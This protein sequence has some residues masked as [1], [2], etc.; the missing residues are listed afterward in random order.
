[1]TSAPTT[2]VDET[3]PQPTSRPVVPQLHV[4]EDRIVGGVAGFIARSFGVDAA[5]VRIGFVLLTLASG[6]GAVLY[7]GLWLVLSADR[8]TRWHW[9]RLVG[10][11]IVVVGIPLIAIA[12]AG[13]PLVDGPAA[14]VLLLAG[15]ALALWRG[16]SGS[17]PSRATQVPDHVAEVTSMS[18]PA[19]PPGQ[20]RL[21]RRE[22]S[23]LG[24]ATLGAAISAAAVGALIDQAN[25]GR[26]HPE[27]WLGAA[28][29]ICGVG[30]LIG[31]LRGRGRWLIVPAMLFAGAGYVAGTAARLGID[32]SDTFGSPSIW[33]GEAS[34]TGARVAHAAIGDVDIQIEQEPA[35]PISVDARVG[36]GSI[37]IWAADDIA[38]EIVPRVDD[39]EVVLNGNEVTGTETI[40]IGPEGPVKV[41]IDAWVGRGDI[42]IGTHQAYREPVEPVEP[43]EPIEPIEPIEPGLRPDASLI[44]VADQVAATP[45]GWFVI[46]NGAAVIDD[47][48]RLV[49]G[50]PVAGDDGVTRLATEWGEFLLLPRGLLITPYGEVLDLQTIREGLQEG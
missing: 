44:T 1:M 5:W 39:G 38:I 45:D 16:P 17:G 26:L 29:V 13:S 10:G 2:D 14:V 18:R 49:V 9:Q 23:V 27:Q 28:A 30:L 43:V 12:N 8:V 33:I 22:P 36:F 32:A 24:R 47:Q 7:V 25:G 34:S 19:P 20:R 37:R 48:D 35:E 40:R 4:D 41:T 46:A 15:L 42:R 11:A 6:I 50:E 3:A 21:P 31:S